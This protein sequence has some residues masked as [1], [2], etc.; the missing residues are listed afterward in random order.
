MRTPS[1]SVSVYKGRC[2]TYPITLYLSLHSSSHDAILV[3]SPQLISA[4]FNHAPLF[5]GFSHEKE[6]GWD[7]SII[8]LGVTHMKVLLLWCIGLASLPFSRSWWL[9]DAITD[10]LGAVEEKSLM[11]CGAQWFLLGQSPSQASNHYGH[12]PV[13]YPRDPED[14]WDSG[15]IGHRILPG[16]L[17]ELRQD[18]VHVSAQHYVHPHAD[19]F[20]APRQML[21]KLNSWWPTWVNWVRVI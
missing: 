7:T 11:V 10:G 20:A 14:G 15:P 8:I 21:A 12:Q 4:C 6:E 1:A 13:V 18:L 5:L 17:T 19:C 2:R 3:E 16:A 9:H